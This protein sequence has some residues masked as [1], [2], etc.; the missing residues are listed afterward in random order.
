MDQVMTTAIELV[1]LIV[2]A[3]IGRYFIPFIKTNVDMNKLELI[4]KWALKFVKSAEN[5]VVGEKMGDERRQM[6]T[7][8]IKEKADE[9]GIKFIHI[10]ISFNK[11][12][13][14]SAN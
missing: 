13:K 11:W 12:Y 1:V 3:L 14:I 4:T 7:D 9:I 6:V 8:W 2:A 5:I 10:Y